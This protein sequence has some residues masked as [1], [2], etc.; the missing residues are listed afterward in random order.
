MDEGLS[1][2]VRVRSINPPG[3]VRTPGYLRGRTG[4]IERVLGRFGDPEALAYGLPPKARRLYRVRF[5]MGEIWGAEAEAPGDT[6]DAEI[7]EHWLEPADD[8]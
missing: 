3:H 7:Y 5:T 8:P 1:G 4:E 6:L 2:R